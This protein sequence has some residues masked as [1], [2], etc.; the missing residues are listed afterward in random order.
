MLVFFRICNFRSIVE[1]TIDMRYGEGKAP[2]GYKEMEHYPFLEYQAENGKVLRLSPVLAIYGLNAGGKTTLVEAMNTL[3]RCL[4]ENKLH[5]RPK[6][7]H[8]D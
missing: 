8:P 7:L 5:Y 1:T 6:K 4:F 3:R 2:N